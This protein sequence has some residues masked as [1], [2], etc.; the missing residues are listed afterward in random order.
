[1]A[2]GSSLT[3]EEFNQEVKKARMLFKLQSKLS[4]KSLADNYAR[5]IAGP[6]RPDMQKIL[7]LLL[8]EADDFQYAHDALILGAEKID[9]QGRSLPDKLQTFVVD[10]AARRRER[11]VKKAPRDKKNHIINQVIFLHMS[12]LVNMGIKLTGDK[13][14]VAVMSEAIPWLSEAKAKKIYYSEQKNNLVAW[15]E[16]K[17]KSKDKL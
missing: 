13:S 14:I 10:V 3:T 9:A 4:G 6:T 1:M 11:P 8:S 5:H 2:W 7:D 12:C 16:K 15:R 17:G